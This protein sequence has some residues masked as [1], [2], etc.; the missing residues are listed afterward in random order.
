MDRMIKVR[1]EDWMDEQLEEYSKARQ[2]TKSIAVRAAIIK[3]LKER[4]F[5]YAMESNTKVS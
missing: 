5:K 1:I 4:G 2:V 3:L